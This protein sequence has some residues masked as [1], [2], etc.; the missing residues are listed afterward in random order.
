MPA[1][2]V[3]HFMQRGE[4][5]LPVCP[6]PILIIFGQEQLGVI[7]AECLVHCSAI[8]EASPKHVHIGQSRWRLCRKVMQVLSSCV[9]QNTVGVHQ[10]SG[11]MLLQKPRHLLYCRWEEPIVIRGPSQILSSRSSM[12]RVQG[13]GKLLVYLVSDTPDAWVPSREL[14]DDVRRGIGRAIIHQD[15]LPVFVG[16]REAAFNRLTEIPGAVIG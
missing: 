2:L 3:Q 15:Q 10:R 7:P 13:L 16:L 14:R 9:D 12:A 11:G 1:V 8:E 5:K 4:L 6:E